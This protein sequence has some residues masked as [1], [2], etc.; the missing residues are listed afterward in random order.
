MKNLLFRPWALLLLPLLVSLACQS[1]A[2]SPAEATQ[3]PEEPVSAEVNVDFGPGPFDFPNPTAGLADLSGYKATVIL[4]F[5]GTVAGSA[6]KW[7]KTYVMLTTKEPS[8]RQL[9]VE[10]TGDLTSLDPVFMAEADGADYERRGENDCNA[11]AIE[12]GNSL[13]DRLEPASFLAGV[14]GA[15]EAGSETVNDTAAH[16]YTFDERAF[17]QPSVVKSTGEMWVATEGGYIV[18]Y[19]L[20]TKGA[21][22]YFGEGIEGTISYDYELTDVNK[23]VTFAPLPADCPAGMVDAPLLPDASNVLN[24]PSILTYDTSSSLVE[25]AAFYQE[26]IPAL[27][28][29]LIGEPSI[30]ETTA[31]LEFTQGNQTMSVIIVA[32]DTGT[33]VQ[34]LLS[35]SQEEKTP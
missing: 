20:T 15:D 35:R 6:S 1:L 8:I 21:A 14:I 29:T 9:T 27:G 2:P 7:T 22:D 10:K 30:G 11:N 13:G 26:Q 5:D 4:S 18:K 3:S 32:D 16:H 31:L 23:P 17:G 19:L 34:I 25:S 33:N 24:M 12:E 28:W